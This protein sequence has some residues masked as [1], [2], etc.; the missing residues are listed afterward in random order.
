[1]FGKGKL[2]IIAFIAVVLLS[3]FGLLR[4]FTL[5]FEKG[6]VFPPYSSLRSDPL[7]C[8]ALFMALERSAGLEARR[9]FRDLERLKGFQGGTIYYMG[10]GEELL[11]ASSDEQVRKLEA[12]AG[13]G[14]RLVIAFG[15]VKGRPSAA[16]GKE[17]KTDDEASRDKRTKRADAAQSRA[18]RGGVW[19][20]EIGAF[21]PP[22]G[23]VKTRPRASLSA[24]ASGLPPT[25]PLHSPHNFKGIGKGW[26][27]VYNYGERAIV[28]ER[29]VG[30]GSIL[31]LAESYLLSNEAL[32]N[33][34]CPGLLAW[35]QGAGRTALF[36]ESHLGV[37]DNPGVMALIK[38]HRLV[39]FLLAL[40]AL[41]ALYV[42][43]SAVP[44]VAMAAPEKEQAEF[45]VRDNF[46]GLVNLLR[47][48][49]A[50]GELLNACFREWSRSFSREFRNNPALGEQ[51]R[52]IVSDEAARSAGKRNPLARYREIARILEKKQGGL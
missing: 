3:A 5:R 29:A 19:G 17:D 11:D 14:N 32:R 25:I 20:L 35:L 49:I 23:P 31:L 51:V 45:G 43:K 30:K 44:F 12:L 52:A 13:E 50:S 24:P 37:Y 22:V 46:S 34:R 42:W 1:M 8:K 6:D 18:G 28:L 9:N 2:L 26:R 40:M 36:D 33:D 39:P 4:L 47:R 27:P 15:M 10:A 16:R 48:N 7:G 38:K 41:A 21:D